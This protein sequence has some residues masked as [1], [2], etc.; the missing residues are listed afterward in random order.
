MRFAGVLRA[1]L[2][3][4]IPMVLLV[5]VLAVISN[6]AATLLILSGALVAVLTL[7]VSA[8]HVPLWK[9][10]MPQYFLYIEGICGLV[11]AAGAF[12]AGK[13]KLIGVLLLLT[14]AVPLLW[15]HGYFAAAIWSAFVLALFGIPVLLYRLASPRHPDAITVA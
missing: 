13:R 1:A 8:Q 3:E 15:G 5:K 2:G 14:P 11:V 9:F 10:G 4:Y 6:I 12:L 7:A